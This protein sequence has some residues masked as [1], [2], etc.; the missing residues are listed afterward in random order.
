MEFSV[1]VDLDLVS[2]FSSD[3]IAAYISLLTHLYS[4][5]HRTH[6]FPTSVDILCFY[7]TDTDEYPQLVYK[8]VNRGLDELQLKGYIHGKQPYVSTIYIP[9]YDAERLLNPKRFVTLYL[10]EI[11]KIMKSRY[12]EKFSVLRYYIL[13]LST[14]HDSVGRMPLETLQD[15]CSLTRKTII[16]YNNILQKLKLIVITQK[17]EGNSN[18]ARNIYAR[19]EDA[20]IIGGTFDEDGELIDI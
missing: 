7:A 11:Q 8:A 6:K 16:S 14:F 15:I 20:E 18:F 4:V 9:G 17:K 10:W 3:E 5:S 13:L 12:L 2:S 19:Y 1:K